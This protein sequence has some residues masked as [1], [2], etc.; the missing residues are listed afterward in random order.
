MKRCSGEASRGLEVVDSLVN[1]RNTEF[2]Y[3]YDKKDFLRC[4]VFFPRCDARYNACIVVR[5]LDTLRPYLAI[6]KR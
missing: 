5:P 2:S 6:V 4:A 3:M 1:W